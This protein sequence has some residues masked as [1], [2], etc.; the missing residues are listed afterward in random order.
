VAEELRR[1]AILALTGAVAAVGCRGG[2][3]RPSREDARRCLEGLD[4][5]VTVVEPAPD[6]RDAPDAELIAN[7]VLR[8]R[9]MLFAGYY[10]DEDTAER[11]EPALRRNARSFDGAVERHGTLTLLWVRDD[12]SGSRSG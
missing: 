1:T 8:G 9:V 12:E 2:G 7:D 5:H 10:D 6:D 11:Y 3:D 4:L